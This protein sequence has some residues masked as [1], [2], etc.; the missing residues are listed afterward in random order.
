MGELAFKPRRNARMPRSD[1]RCPA[2]PCGRR[3]GGPRGVTAWPCGACTDIRTEC[4]DAGS[5]ACEVHYSHHASGTDRRLDVVRRL[6]RMMIQTHVTCDSS[7]LRAA[8]ENRSRPSRCQKGLCRTE[9]PAQCSRRSALAVIAFSWDMQSESAIA[10]ARRSKAS[11]GAPYAS[12]EKCARDHSE[13]WT[14]YR[15]VLARCPM[16]ASRPDPVPPC[17]AETLVAAAQSGL[18]MLQ[19]RKVGSMIH[20]GAPFRGCTRGYLRKHEPLTARV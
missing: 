5:K 4:R 14:G 9:V 15:P 12:M 11:W 17:M 16:R 20:F 7:P 6:T 2:H 8:R 3:T 13:A 18:I 19:P 1:L 10:G